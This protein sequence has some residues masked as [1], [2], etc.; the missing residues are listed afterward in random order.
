MAGLHSPLPLTIPHLAQGGAERYGDAPAILENDERWSYR[1]LYEQIR[2]AASAMLK[3]GITRGD[4]VAI[5]A[6]NRREWIVAAIAGQLAGA[7]IVPLNTRLKGGEASDLLRRTSA[8]MLFTV[9]EFLGTDYPA[10]IADERIPALQQTVCFDRDWDSFIGE[11]NANDRQVDAALA[12][13]T[14][15]DISD[16]MF[17]SGTTGVPKGVLTT[18]SRIIPMFANW[19]KLVDLREGDPYLIINPFFH[20]F[21][22]K[23]GF[24][25]AMIVGAL[26]VPM[27]IFDVKQVIKHIEQDR[28]A[29][30]PG[31]PTIYQSLLAE[32][33]GATFDH[34][35]LR[36]AMTGAASVPPLLIRR[37]VDELGFDRVLTAY[38]MTE[39]TNITACQPG[40]APELVAHSCG[41][42]IPGMEVIIADDDGQEVAQG[43]TGEIFVRG[44]GV[45]LGYLDDP[46]ATAETIDGE[47]W[48][49]TGDVGTMD[50]NGYVRITD[51]KKDMFISGGFNCYPAEVEKLLAAHPAIEMVAVIGVPDERMGEIG[52]AFVVLKRGAE[53]DEAGLIAWARENMANYKAPRKAEFLDALPQTASGKIMK[54]ELSA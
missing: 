45:M 13:C 5:W 14:A 11:G 3:I 19:T 41:K 34:T 37:M 30:I 29:F 50:D 18:H 47:G 36:S 43:E 1:Q 26:V 15:D 17:T 28:I 53:L 51:R 39:C 22:F 54:R 42:A 31:P 16:I 35:S 52:K 25:A 21:G 38:G 4:R 27:A 23:A 9:K 24:V 49:H 48:L 44:Y 20:S 8:K 12:A 10:M 6:P 2:I 40:D 7:A 32:L 33:D 46:E